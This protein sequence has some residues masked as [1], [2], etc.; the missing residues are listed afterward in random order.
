MSSLLDI[1]QS[2]F[3]GGMI[4]FMLILF[5]EKMRNVSDD[6]VSNNIVQSNA[7]EIS[8]ILEYDLLKIGYNES[9]EEIVIAAKKDSIGFLSDI[10]NNG[11]V[12]SVFYSVTDSSEV[13]ETENINDKK[14]LRK[15]NNEQPKIIGKLTD[16]EITYYDSLSNE[17]SISQLINQ[18]ERIKISE[19]GIKLRVESDFKIDDKYQQSFWNKKIKIKNNN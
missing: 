6:L 13:L 11:K 9:S 14:L 8:N 17:L 15:L 5:N 12:D 4:F 7:I 16:F 2:I 10:D 1:V 3:I 18:S 19:I